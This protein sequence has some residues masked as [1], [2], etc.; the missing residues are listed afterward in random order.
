MVQRS[1]A[2]LGSWAC[3]VVVNESKPVVGGLVCRVKRHTGVAVRCSI[4]HL[5]LCVY[6]WRECVKSVHE[7]WKVEYTNTK[8]KINANNSLAETGKVEPLLSAI[9]CGYSE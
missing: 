7:Y 9:H 2:N 6:I 4:V 8:E 1:L 5:T 3:E